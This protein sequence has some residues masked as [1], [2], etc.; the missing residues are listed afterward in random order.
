M[1]IAPHRFRTVLD[2]TP[3]DAALVP[4]YLAYRKLFLKCADHPRPWLVNA[5]ELLLAEQWK[6]ADLAAIQGAFGMNRYLGDAD[7]EIQAS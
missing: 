2:N 4:C 5:S 3:G 6:A 7:F 1:R